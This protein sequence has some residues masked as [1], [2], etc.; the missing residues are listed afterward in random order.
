MPRVIESLLD[1]STV[2][3]FIRGEPHQLDEDRVLAGAGICSVNLAEVIGVLL[4]KGVPDERIISAIGGLGLKVVPLDGD[5]ATL[6]GRLIPVAR[7]LRIGLGDCAC[8]ATG[9]TLG[10]PIYTG[11]RDW[12]KLQVEADIKLIR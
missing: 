3:A 7:P 6:A 2:L 1:S 12:L 11:D 8:I 10:V 9:M 4:V 5:A